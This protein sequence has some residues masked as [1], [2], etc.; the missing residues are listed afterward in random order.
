MLNALR[1]S[2]NRNPTN[3]TL[4]PVA[5]AITLQTMHYREHHIG[6]TSGCYQSTG[7]QCT[8]I[9]LFNDS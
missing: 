7:H 1:A 2:T 5:N 4:S 9:C 3:V 6:C 8:D